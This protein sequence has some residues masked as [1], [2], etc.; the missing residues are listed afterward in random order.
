MQTTNYIALI[1]KLDAFIRKYY[2]NRLIK[3][4]L[5]ST[6]LVAGFFLLMVLLES[7]GRFGTQ[8]RTAFFFSFLLFLLIVVYR[9]IAIPVFKLFQIGDQISQEQAAEIIGTHFSNVSDK[10]LNTIELK[11]ISE[12]NQGQ[13]DLIEASIEQRS[14]ELKPVPFSAAINLADN[15]KYLKYALPP[16]AIILILVFAA[17]SLI[18]DSTVRIIDFDEH[19]EIPMPFSFELENDN[20]TAVKNEDF[21]LLISVEGNEIPTE[22]FIEVEGLKYQMDK[23]P[24]NQYAYTARNLQQKVEFKFYASGFYSKDYLLD[25]FPRPAINQSVVYLN[26][27][28]Y[29]NVSDEELSGVSDVFVPEGTKLR[30]LLRTKHTNDILISIGDSV[31]NIDKIK[32]DEFSLDFLASNK[33]NIKAILKDNSKGL[34]DSLS[35]L[36]NIIRDE[37]PKLNIKKLDDSL[38]VGNMYFS[39]KASDDYGFSSL[40]FIYQINKGKEM[41]ENISFSSNQNILEFYHIWNYSVLNLE[42]N[43]EITYF[44][45]AFDN[46]GVNG[47][48][49]VRSGAMVYK[50]SSEREIQEKADK[51]SEKTKKDLQASIEDAKN[52]AQ[53]IEKLNKKMIEKKTLNWEEKKQLEELLKKQQSLKENFEKL[54]KQNELNNRKRNEFSPQ[55]EE[56]LKKQKQLEELM[57]KVLDEEMKKMLEDIQKMM[58]E[59]NKQKMQEKLEELKLDNKDLEKEL[60]RSLELFKQFEFEQKMEDIKKNLDDLKKKQNDLAEKTLDKNENADSLNKKQEEI[61]KEFENIKKDLKDLEKKNNDLEKKNDLPKLD[62][63]KKKAS[64][65]MSES[66]EQNS[67]GNKKKSS[68]S[69]K[70]AADQMEKMEKKLEAAQEKMEAEQQSE[71]LEKLRRLR[72]GLLELSFTQERLIESVSSTGGNDPQFVELTRLQKKL[73]DDSKMIEDSLY[74]LSKRNIQ[75]QSMVNKEIASINNNLT[76][77]VKSMA[78]RKIPESLNRQQYVMTSLNKLALMLDESIQQSQKEQSSKKFGKKSCSKPGGGKPSMGDMKKAQESLSKQLKS[79]Q[80]QMKKGGKKPGQK[81]GGGMRG[82]KMSEQ[83]AKMAGEQNALRNELRNMMEGMQGEK[84]GKKAG[85]ELKKIQDLMEKNEGDLVN[86]QITRETLNR[87]EEIMSRLLESEK[88]ERER[89]FD[90]KRESEVGVNQRI[91]SDILE[92]YLQMKG[93]QVEL[94]ET[95]PLDLKP[96]YKNKVNGY[97]NKF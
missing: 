40:R 83:A 43:D 52:L 8:V 60:D 2:T 56:L 77:V 23:L 49:R 36:V 34:K 6:G 44:F 94:M 35:L 15:R 90:N 31:L 22:V 51:S 92:E 80:E 81:P 12:L 28:K 70:E 76:K 95:I 71:D 84:G 19:Y 59:A 39:G 1:D 4:S 41:R 10:L 87:Q 91:N 63:E 46:D 64:D 53:E 30:W 20:L 69:R 93:K 21:K 66:K 33:S 13:S 73:V 47:P 17:P 48:K 96:F 86:M 7:A 25:V 54:K 58:E 55:S 3:G 45:E 24:G 75:I 14:L 57:N 88:S 89:E 72:Q 85:E 61:E 11:K 50:I 42:P 32:D 68:E 82:S 78:D 16:L 9:F 27:P 5:Y 38:A 67:A 62:E 65:K 79:L 74:A 29:L 26:Y 18:K 97:Y 37:Y